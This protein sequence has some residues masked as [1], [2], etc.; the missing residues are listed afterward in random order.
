MVAGGVLAG[1][2]NGPQFAI[3]VNKSPASRLFFKAQ[4]GELSQ[5]IFVVFTS[6]IF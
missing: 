1:H 5:L 6:F 4:I 3:S 2:R